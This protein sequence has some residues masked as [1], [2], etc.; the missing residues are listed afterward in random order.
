MSRIAPG[1]MSRT[2]PGLMSRTAP[3]LMSATRFFPSSPRR[4]GAK[5]RGGEFFANT[6]PSAAPTPLLGEEGN[7]QEPRQ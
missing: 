1:L 5:R 3:G 2:A 4:G 6:T 7:K